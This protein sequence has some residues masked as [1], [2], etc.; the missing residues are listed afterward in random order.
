MVLRSPAETRTA[1]T[2]TLLHLEKSFAAIKDTKPTGLMTA[3]ESALFAVGASLAEFVITACVFNKE[4]N[5]THSK[6][7]RK[8]I[9]DIGITLTNLKNVQFLDVDAAGYFP[10]FKK[11]LHPLYLTHEAATLVIATSKFLNAKA[12]ETNDETRRE[13]AAMADL[14]REV[15][16]VVADKAEE[17]RNKMNGDGWMDNILTWLREEPVGDPKAD[18]S[19]WWDPEYVHTMGRCVTRELGDEFCEMWAGELITS[20]RESVMGLA[21][22]HSEETK[23]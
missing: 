23:K 13:M 21:A 11:T 6:G 16:R 5:V 10:D 3:H 7:P 20:W 12:V 17:V 18:V 9:V 2:A 22:L 8:C 19:E 15:Y 1:I 4:S 14:A